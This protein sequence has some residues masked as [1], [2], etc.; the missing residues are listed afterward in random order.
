MSNTRAGQLVSMRFC[1]A[2]PVGY[3]DNINLYVYTNNDPTDATDPTGLAGQG[4]LSNGAWKKV[5]QPSQ[6]AALKAV[7]GAIARLKS[8]KKARADLASGKI[9]A[10]PRQDRA[11]ETA[12]MKAFGSSADSTVDFTATMFSCDEAVLSDGGRSITM[13]SQRCRRR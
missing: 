4:T 7:R 3:K 5:V 8:L 12:M 11:T 2:D 9:K 1:Q 6:L 13:S 10:L